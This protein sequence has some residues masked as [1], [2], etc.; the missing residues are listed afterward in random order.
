MKALTEQGAPLNDEY[1]PEMCA[2]LCS[3]FMTLSSMS[4]TVTA[5]L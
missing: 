2:S 5:S 4:R 3:I 1:E